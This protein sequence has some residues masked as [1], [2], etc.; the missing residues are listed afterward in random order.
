MGNE[1]CRAC[2]DC[3]NN[4]KDEE[5]FSHQAN[6][7][8]TNINNPIFL[9]QK[10]TNTINDILPNNNESIFKNDNLNK[11]ESIMITN[12]NNQTLI[13]DLENNQD[14]RLRGVNNY[15]I[16]NEAGEKINKYKTINALR[17]I[18]KLFRELK[19][20]KNNSHQIL[21]KELSK[22][23]SS[24]FILDIEPENL[25]VNLVPE[26]N[27]LYLGNKFKN[28]KDGE[29][30]EL[31][32][33]SNAKYFGYFRNGRR[34][35]VGKFNISN[36]TQDY[37]FY[38]EIQGIYALGFGILYNK[39]KSISYEGMWKNSMKNGLGVEAHADG[40]EYRGQFLN[41]KKDGIGCYKWVDN[42]LYEGE[43]KNDKLNGY[44]IY[45]FKDGSIYKGEW[46][47]NRMNGLGEFSSPGIKS[48]I[49][50]FHKDSREGFGMLIWLKEN[51][52]FIGFWKNNVQN[53]IG[54][55]IVN[56]KIRYGIWRDGE[57]SQKIKSKNEFNNKIG[58]QEKIYWN[59]LK[60]EDYNDI[61]QLIRDV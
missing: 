54:K 39:K 59:Y 56:K 49:G 42:S 45:Q 24:E 18:I 37:I 38:G 7:P 46:K 28:K 50:F 57:L 26:I 60:I 47:N 17:K 52:I 58:E 21:T 1:F 35:D 19:K 61:L 51:K 29:G 31:F 36:N 20:L 3:T 27:C 32:S 53:G 40:S 14:S 34:V 16:D 11:E 55:F 5:D 9:N 30:L 2:K 25:D 41:G 10:T 8:L 44:G 4:G 43:W 23:S 22:I 12:N 6:K 15:I 33:T 48:Y 13:N